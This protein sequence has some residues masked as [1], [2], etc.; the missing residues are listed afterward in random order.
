[1]VV[2]LRTISRNSIDLARYPYAE[3]YPK[4]PGLGAIRMGKG[5]HLIGMYVI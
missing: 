3:K 1:M 4:P 5:L 2:T